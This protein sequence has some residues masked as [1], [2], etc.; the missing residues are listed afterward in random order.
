ML[1]KI[2]WTGLFVAIALLF[3]M[4]I[5]PPCP[6]TY[7]RKVEDWVTHRGT[8]APVVGAVVKIRA[9]NA[10]PHAS[11]TSDLA[12]DTADTAIVTDSN[13]RY[14]FYVPPG[15]YDIYITYTNWG[16]SET[17]SNFRVGEPDTLSDYETGLPRGYFYAAAADSDLTA[18]QYLAADGLQMLSV[19]GFPM[20]HAGSIRSWCLRV[21]IEAQGA[22]VDTMLIQVRKN[23]TEVARSAKIVAATGWAQWAGFNA[24]GVDTFL[25]SDVL[26]L[27]IEEATG[28]TLT[29]SFPQAVLGVDFDY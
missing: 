2:A 19:V 5:A 8:G 21:K 28:A 26:Q 24:T 15:L 9:A 27:Y 1:R 16:I 14:A 29:Y 12:G 25:V 20:P 22:G 17:L 6:A 13:G 4:V 7:Y 23:G 11:T 18:S 3:W 10:N